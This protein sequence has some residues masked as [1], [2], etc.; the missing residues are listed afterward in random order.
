MKFLVQYSIISPFVVRNIV[1]PTYCIPI[2]ED[3]PTIPRPSQ[4][5]PWFERSP[6]DKQTKQPNNLVFMDLDS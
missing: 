5:V 4:E 6:H 3:F 1:K 2:I